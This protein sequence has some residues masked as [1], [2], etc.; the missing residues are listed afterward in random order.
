MGFQPMSHR[1]DA[2]ATNARR[3]TTRPD[4]AM[5]ARK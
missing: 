2:D 1:Q 4:C 3:F 5:V